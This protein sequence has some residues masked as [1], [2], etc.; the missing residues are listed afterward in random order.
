MRNAKEATSKEQEVKSRLRH[1]LEDLT[2]H[3]HGCENLKFSTMM[4][5]KRM[6]LKMM[7]TFMTELRYESEI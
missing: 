6:M 5:M 7:M 3:S 2:I 4:M 1:S